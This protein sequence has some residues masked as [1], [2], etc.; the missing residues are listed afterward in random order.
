MTRRF[1]LAVCTSPRIRFSPRPRHAERDHEL[2]AGERLAVEHEDQ[3]LGIVETAFLQ[4]AQFTRAR[5]DEPTRHTRACEAKRLR[6]RFGRRLVFPT[7]KTAQHA[8]EEP[9]VLGPRGL[10]RRIRRQR[11]F[12]ARCA[13][14]HAGDGDRQLLVGE[15]DRA[16][17]LAPARD[18]RSLIIAAIPRPRHRQ[19]FG[20]QCVLDG[21]QAQR[22]QRLNHRQ[23]CRRRH[24]SVVQ[25][26]RLLLG[27]NAA[28]PLVLRRAPSYSFHGWCPREGVEILGGIHTLVPRH[29]LLFN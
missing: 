16:R 13:I 24:G 29:H 3:P 20:D 7:R 17:L 22:N 9:H 12:A 5:A 19:D 2:I 25:R 28:T 8:A 6:H 4:P 14:A 15:E 11:D 1:S 10:Q 18:T 27:A 21:L 26:D 23:R